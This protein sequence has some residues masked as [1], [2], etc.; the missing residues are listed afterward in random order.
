[1]TTFKK[2]S[3]AGAA[4]AAALLAGCDKPP[5]LP[6][7]NEENC[8]PENIAKLAKGAQQEFSSQCLRRGSFQPSEQKTW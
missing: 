1:M 7:V 8:R 4:L 5:V 6:E 3:L 2:L